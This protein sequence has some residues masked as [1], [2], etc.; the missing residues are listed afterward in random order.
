MNSPTNFEFMA[1]I[2]YV[3]SKNGAA[4]VSETKRIIN[5]TDQIKVIPHYPE[6]LPLGTDLASVKPYKC[7]FPNNITLPFTKHQIPGTG[8]VQ[9]NIKDNDSDSIKIHPGVSDYI[10]EFTTNNFYFVKED[11]CAIYFHH[12]LPN[13]PY[14]EGSVVPKTI[15][16][17]IEKPFNRFMYKLKVYFINE[18]SEF[19]IECL[20]DFSKHINMKFIFNLTQHQNYYNTIF[21][22][23][24]FRL[25]SFIPQLVKSAFKFISAKFGA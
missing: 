16:C 24:H 4:C 6:I 15:E 17:I 11:V 19:D 25:I 12:S 5:N 3:V 7:T 2:K 20:N 21:I 10:T 14:L 9:I 23:K 22:T 13:L 8:R 1:N 18:P